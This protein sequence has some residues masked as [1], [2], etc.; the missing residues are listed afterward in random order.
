M[1]A[2]IIRRLAWLP[3]ILLIVSFITFVLAR[4]GPG[5][6]ISI[7]AGQIRD[8]EVLAQVRAD[9]GLDDGL[10]E[11]YLRWLGGAVQGD[12]GDSYIQQGYSVSEL[13]FPK[14]W[15]SAQLG[16]LALIIIFVVGIPLG[17]VAAR[18]AGTWADPAIIGSLLFLQAIP[19]LVLI[20]PLLWLFSLQLGLLPV[21]GWDGLFAVWWVGGV[22]AIPIPNPHLYL[23]LIA[24]TLPGFVGVARLVRISA[25]EVNTLDYVRTAR[26]KGL[27]EAAV[28]F[29]HVFPNSLLPLVTVFGLALSGIIEGALFV[30]TLL[31]I[32][33]IGRFLFE[34]VTSRDYDVIMAATVIFASAFVLTNLLAE[35]AYGLID[36]RI[37]LG[38]SRG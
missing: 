5:D 28:Q 36:P 24:F 16:I 15:I 6:P 8:P 27:S 30:E 22:I 18:L 31:G 35:I 11:Q 14:M 3:V 17:L 13:I 19:V 34:A 38:A 21:G 25:L 26:A 23:P 29:R 9:R 10:V 7:A 33:G 1:T 37:R 12:F 2:Y 20:P 32:P 4:F